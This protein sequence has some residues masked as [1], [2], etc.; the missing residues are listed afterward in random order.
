[1]GTVVKTPAIRKSFC[2]L[3]LKSAAFLGFFRDFAF[4]KMDCFASF[5][6]TG[7]RVVAERRRFFRGVLGG[8]GWTYVTGAKVILA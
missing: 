5:A 8:G 4:E 7:G 6:M 1:M 2:A 3:F